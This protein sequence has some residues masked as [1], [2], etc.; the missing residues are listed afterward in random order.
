MQ[1]IIFNNTPLKSEAHPDHNL[2]RLLESIE[3]LQSS[4][5]LYP[6]DLEDSALEPL[7]KLERKVADYT[8]T[9]IEGLKQKAAMVSKDYDENADSNDEERYT[10][11]ALI[12]SI[13]RNIEALENNEISQ[14]KEKD[15]IDFRSLEPL[16]H[17]VELLTKLVLDIELQIDGNTEKE[18]ILIAGYAEEKAK[19]LREKYL[20]AY[21]N[22]NKQ[23]SKDEQKVVALHKASA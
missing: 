21:K 1:K 11:C 13:F 7:T 8:P 19:E 9:T 2:W 23:K 17:D 12:K 18:R 14:Q 5:C 22:A 4:F 3:H 20:A 6:D 15:E 16:V 10:D